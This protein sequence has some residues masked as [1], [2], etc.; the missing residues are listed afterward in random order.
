MIVVLKTTLT[1][2]KDTDKTFGKLRSCVLLYRAYT[3]IESSWPGQGSRYLLILVNFPV[4]IIATFFASQLAACSYQPRNRVL[5]IE[6][7]H[8]RSA[9]MLKPT[10]LEKGTLR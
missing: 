1:S 10:R 8:A 7:T 4:T 3:Y 9:R 2:P 5:S 6:M